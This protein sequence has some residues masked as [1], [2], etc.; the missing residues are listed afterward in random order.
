MIVPT[1]KCIEHGNLIEESSSASSL[2]CGLSNKFQ[3]DS[4]HAPTIIILLH[5]IMHAHLISECS[6]SL[7]YVCI[8]SCVCFVYSTTDT[9]FILF[10][11]D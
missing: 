3:M 6:V 2:L 5:V 9:S 8:S 7:Q 1:L 10:Y 4:M 11:H